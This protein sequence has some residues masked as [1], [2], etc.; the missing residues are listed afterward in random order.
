MSAADQGWLDPATWERVQ[1]I[2]PI[3]CVD[4]MAVRVKAGV[5]VGLILRETPHEGRRWCLV[6]GRLRRGESLSHAVLREVDSALGPGLLE[7]Q[8]SGRASSIVEYAPEPAGIGPHDPRKHAIGLTYVV[9]LLGEP[10]PRNE[11]LDFAWFARAELPTAGF[12][13]RGVIEGLLSQVE[14]ER[15]GDSAS[16]R[17]C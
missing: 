3:V 10:Q 16:G 17:V 8:W 15:R 4:V 5:E 1:Q 6:G 14:A 12:G 13:Q 9:E 7:S 2:V 11:A